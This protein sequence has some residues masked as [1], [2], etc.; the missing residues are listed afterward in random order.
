MQK[1]AH[2]DVMHGDKIETV[3]FILL[4]FT[5]YLPKDKKVQFH[6]QVDRSTNQ[7]KV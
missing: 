6:D 1:S 5:S 2:I 7:T 4:P 3:Y